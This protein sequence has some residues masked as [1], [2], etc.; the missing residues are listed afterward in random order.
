MKTATAVLAAVVL[1]G[2]CRSPPAEAQAPPGPRPGEAASGP[3]RSEQ[4]NTLHQQ[5][6]ELQGQIEREFD[7]LERA[8]IQGFLRGLHEQ[9]ERC[10]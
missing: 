4:C 8:R 10:R 7:P 1:A 3:E 9:E 5:S 6:A 2:I